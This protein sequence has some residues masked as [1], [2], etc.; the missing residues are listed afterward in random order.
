M[1]LLSS[2]FKTKKVD[3]APKI[4]PLQPYQINPQAYGDLSTLSH[5]YLNDKGTGF[6]ED[7]VNKTTNP[8]ADAMRRNFRQFTAP[9]TA[10][11]YSS[12]G[13]GK[14]SLAANELGRQE[15]DVESNVGQLMAQ[16]YRLNEAQK[17]SD[18]Q[19]GANVGQNL[20][21][22]DVAAQHAQAAASE[23]LANATAADT[24][25]RETRD[26]GLAGNIMQAG[27]QLLGPIGGAVSGIG[28]GIGGPVGGFLQSIGG[29]SQAISNAFPQQS[30]TTQILG[31]MNAQQLQ[32]MDIQT[33]L[34]L[35]EAA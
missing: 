21:S 30:S 11:A 14:S 18:I 19:F 25:A 9:Q 2:L 10:S 12:R 26:T 24:R 29:Q 5:N 23:R 28:G 3:L 8:V 17:K 33:L 20:L 4:V 16:F 13:L 35:L 32:G 1:S 22:G 7:F 6:G 31:K 15:G 34:A 27:A